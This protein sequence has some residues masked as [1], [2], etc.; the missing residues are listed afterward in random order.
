MKK[1]V[2]MSILL[3]ASLGIHFAGCIPDKLPAVSCESPATHRRRRN[4]K[5]RNS[6]RHAGCE[7]PECRVNFCQNYQMKKC[8]V[9]CLDLLD[10]YLLVIKNQ[11]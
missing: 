6:A 9:D 2:W 4:Q 3:F 8:I 7:R 11:E 1:L 5:G 10:L